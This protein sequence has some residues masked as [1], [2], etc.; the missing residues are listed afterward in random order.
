MVAMVTKRTKCTAR[1]AML[2][3]IVDHCRPCIQFASSPSQSSIF[4][5]IL[6]LGISLLFDLKNWTWYAASDNVWYL[7]KSY[8]FNSSRFGCHRPTAVAQLERHSGE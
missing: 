2:R 1:L 8:S 4:V 3:A 5:R 6:T 7:F